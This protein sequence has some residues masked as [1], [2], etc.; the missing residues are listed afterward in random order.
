MEAPQQ[1]LRGSRFL[2]TALF[3]VLV[4]FGVCTATVYAAYQSSSEA[5]NAKFA[6]LEQQYKLPS[7][8]LAALANAESSMNASVCN[9]QACGLFQWM[10]KSWVDWTKQIYGTPKDLSLRKNPFIAA[11]VTA[12]RARSALNKFQGLISQ[13]KLDPKLALR[14]EHFFGEG[15]FG[16][17]IRGYIQNP[18]GIAASVVPAAARAN[19]SIFNNGSAT[20]VDVLNNLAKRFSAGV[21]LSGY[22]PTF[23][24]ASQNGRILDTNSATAVATGNYTGGAL[25]ADPYSASSPVDYSAAAQ[26]SGAGASG[27]SSGSSGTGTSAPSPLGGTGASTNSNMC[28]PRYY[29]NGQ[30]A[31][32]QDASCNTQTLQTCSQSQTCQSGLCVSA[33]NNTQPSPYSFVATTSISTTTTP[34]QTATLVLQSVANTNDAVQSVFSPSAIMQVLGGGAAVSLPTPTTPN[35]NPFNQISNGII[36]TLVPGGSQGYAYVPSQG[37][38]D[39]TSTYAADSTGISTPQLLLSTLSSLGKALSLAY[40]FFVGK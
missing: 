19:P 26:P 7:G 33:L 10:P 35:T 12:A 38:S 29:C 2:K 5:L 36:K 11:E 16:K 24:D 4:F 34:Q 40:S 14:A 3:S 15:D 13:A 25:P 23:V 1:K 21:A 27:G 32:M 31:M 9:G 17:F 22:S 8:Y 28:S 18:K 30:T 37:A 39:F 20:F 6:Q